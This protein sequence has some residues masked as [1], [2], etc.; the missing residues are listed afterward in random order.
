MSAALRDRDVSAQPNL[1]PPCRRYAAGA[2]GRQLR[3]RFEDYNA[4]FTRITRRA[5]RHFLAK[6]WPAARADAVQRIELYERHVSSAIEALRHELGAAIH[7]RDLWVEVKRRFALQIADLPDSD[8]Y[9]TFLNSI[10]R[11]VFATIG[12][13]EEIEFTAT[14]AGRASGSVP[15]RVHPVG[16]SL[17]RAVSELLKDLPFASL[18][19]D[20]ENFA[21]RDLP[22]ID[23]AFRQPAAECRSTTGGSHRRPFLSRRYGQRRRPH[24][25][26]RQHHAVRHRVSPC[27]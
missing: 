8:F 3:R 10:T 18:I 24:D 13:D 27:R 23:A 16:D 14:A 6:D 1:P 17:Q 9:R 15:I 12:V 7:E 5:A 2:A 19:A 22:R 4:E 21:R 11:D 20:V 26:R 25:R